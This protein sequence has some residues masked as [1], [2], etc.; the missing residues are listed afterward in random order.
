M[1]RKAIAELFAREGAKI[2]A[3]DLN[4]NGVKL[5]V[6]KINQAS[7]EAVAVRANVAN[8]ADID[9][10]FDSAQNSFHGLDILVNNAGI[11]DNTFFAKK[12]GVILN[13]ASVGGT[14]GARA[15]AAYVNRAVLPVDGAWAAY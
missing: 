5:V 15:G 1:M 12:H 14:H 6:K 9:N 13:I 2:I 4:E 10:L 8:Q 3:G 7:G 11:M